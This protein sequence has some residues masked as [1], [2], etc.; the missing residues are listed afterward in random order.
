MAAQ[1]RA[2]GVD[3]AVAATLQQKIDDAARAK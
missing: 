2:E 3:A 1:L